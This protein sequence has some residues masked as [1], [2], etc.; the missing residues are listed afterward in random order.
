MDFLNGCA[1]R[2]ETEDSSL[3][4]EDMRK[5]YTTVRCLRVKTGIV[6]KLYGGPSSEAFENK[7]NEILNEEHDEERKAWVKEIVTLKDG[8]GPWYGLNNYK[9]G[10]YPDLEEKLAT[11]PKR[12]PENVL[13]LCVTKSEIKECKKLAY[14]VKLKS[15]INK[16]QV[17]AVVLLNHCRYVLDNH[18]D[19]G[20]YELALALIMVT[21]RRMCEIM[22]GKSRF[23]QIEGK[24]FICMFSGQ[25]KKKSNNDSFEIPLLYN[26]SKINECLTHL[27]RL[28]GSIPI[29]NDK[30]SS[31]YAS[32]MRQFLLNNSLYSHVSKIHNLRKIYTCLCIKLFVWELHTEMYIAMCILGHTN[33][34]EPIVYN[35]IDLGNIDGVEMLGKA[36]K[37]G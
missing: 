1:K 36:P 18:K 27:R 26:V 9:Y 10:L 19:N 25:A 24:Q 13:K 32:G 11:L 6:R 2:L 31:K 20:L 34:Y 12:L 33:L 3:I 35:V 30:V 23:E 4:L 22:N 14:D 15:N 21:G 8:K 29:T 16:K 28:Q 37:I 7:V 17:N 5:R